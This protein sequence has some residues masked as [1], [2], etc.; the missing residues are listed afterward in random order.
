M[1]GILPPIEE[2]P[3]ETGFS[4]A[5]GARLELATNGLTV[6]C[7]AELSY[8]GMGY[9]ASGR[10][11]VS[12][13]RRDAQPWHNVSMKLRTAL[14]FGVGYVLGSRAGRDRYEQLRRLYRRATSN[15][16]VRQVIDQ[17]KEV[18]DSNTEQIRDIAADQMKNVGEAI[19]NRADA[20][21]DS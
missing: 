5:P 7:S 12:D 14:V 8:P 13:I 18:I 2:N 1:P 6:R 4:C 21:N 10:R 16:R 3:V 9:P 15:E 19:R 17:G 20:D 11:M